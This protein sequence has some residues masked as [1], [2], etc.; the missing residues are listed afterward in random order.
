MVI[1]RAERH[2]QLR[3]LLARQPGSQPVTNGGNHMKA[4]TKDQAEGTLHE[5]TGALKEQVGK[6]TGN[7]DLED[8]GSAEKLK[9]KIEQVIAKVEKV[10][11]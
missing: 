4:S 6:V 11:E 5:I 10:L 7:T 2:Y 3:A 1:W 9:G 8:E